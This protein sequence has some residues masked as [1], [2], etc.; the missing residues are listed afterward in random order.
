[1]AA[2]VSAQ[3]VAG[4]GPGAMMGGDGCMGTPVALMHVKYMIVYDECMNM[5][6]VRDEATLAA[7]GR[8]NLGFPTTRT[9]GNLA[10][11]WQKPGSPRRGNLAET[12]RKP[13]GNLA[14][15]W[16]KPGAYHAI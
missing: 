1:M 5:E 12:W 3:Q 14:E 10:E 2:A 9:G 7:R 6:R 13:C 8:G 11:T 15:T 4:E 16:R